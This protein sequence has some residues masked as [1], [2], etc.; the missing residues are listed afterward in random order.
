MLENRLSDGQQQKL[1]NQ[2]SQFGATLAILSLLFIGIFI[3]QQE[4]DPE[5]E[6]Y[7][8]GTEE[9]FETSKSK[10][11]EKTEGL[12]IDSSSVYPLLLND[13]GKY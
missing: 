11:K 5:L 2:F 3:Q 4:S 13:S 1:Q 12:F 7:F 9:V 10:A 8:P 6:K